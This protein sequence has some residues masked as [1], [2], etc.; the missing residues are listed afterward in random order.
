[1]RYADFGTFYS[2]PVGT[3]RIAIETRVECTALTGTRLRSLQ[4]IEVQL[5]SKE[6]HGIEYELLPSVGYV[7]LQTERNGALGV[8][9]RVQESG[10]MAAVFHAPLAES[11]R[12]VNVAEL[13]DS[14]LVRTSDGETMH[15]HPVDVRVQLFE[16]CMLLNERSVAA[17]RTIAQFLAEATE[18]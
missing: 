5:Y 3:L 15:L 2:K 8:R 10:S 9:I 18:L 11:D 12:E 1:M 6:M 13:M 4:P 14:G 17:G 16:T 7:S